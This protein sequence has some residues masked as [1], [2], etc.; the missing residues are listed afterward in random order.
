MRPQ[1]MMFLGLIFAAGTIIS[2][3]FGGAWLG[4]TDL[5]VANAITI[6]KQANILGVWSI[7]VPNISFFFTGAKSLMMFDFAFFNGSTAI[8]QWFLFFTIGLGTMWGFYTVI[9]GVIQGVFTR[10]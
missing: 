7:T 2:L 5:E 6:F 3:T 10:H 4:S 9:I 8:L 1:H